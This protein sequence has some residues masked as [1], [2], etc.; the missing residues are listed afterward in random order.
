MARKRK[1]PERKPAARVAGLLSLG[2]GAGVGVV[3]RHPRLFGGTACFAIVFGFV[4]ANALWYQPGRHPSPWLRT[5]DASDFVALVGVNN[6]ALRERNPEEVTTYRIEREQVTA[7]AVRQPS[8]GQREEAALSHANTAPGDHAALDQA[9]LTRAVQRELKT[10]GLYSGVDDGVAGPMTRAA[11]AA[12]QK[13]V[14]MEETGT[15]SPELLA[16]LRI[17]SGATAAIPLSRPAGDL[18]SGEAAFDPVAAAI[19]SAER[20]IVTAPTPKKPVASP[21]A[22]PAALPA[23]A[24]L[25]MKI[26][27]G[28]ANIAYAEVTVDG[29]AGE[30]TRAAIR[31]FERHYRLPETGVPSE[32]VLKKLKSIGA[33]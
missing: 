4:A 12:F 6:N 31:H 2:I 17:D 8:G 29:V 24:S 9:D 30:Q 11:I 22:T 1:S 13:K 26:Q 18:D 15:A 19:R 21:A 25:V 5:R 33:L 10:R 23:D 14:G 27:Q 16:A 28:L 32:A 3:A 7:P 20:T